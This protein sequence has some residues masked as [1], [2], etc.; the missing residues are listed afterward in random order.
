MADVKKYTVVADN[1]Y[2]VPEEQRLALCKTCQ[3]EKGQKMPL[4]PSESQ[5]VFFPARK[6]YAIHGPC[7]QCKGDRWAFVRKPPVQAQAE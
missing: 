2:M 3:K 5:L 6:T 4:V 7:S 1:I